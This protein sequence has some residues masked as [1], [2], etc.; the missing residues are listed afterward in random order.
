[1]QWIAPTFEESLLELRDQ[2]LRQR[3]T[4]TGPSNRFLKLELR[5]SRR[6]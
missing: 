2:F 1:M 3:K 5:A 6:V 4:L